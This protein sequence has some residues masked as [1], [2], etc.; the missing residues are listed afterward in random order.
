MIKRA[1]FGFTS[2]TSHSALFD[3]ENAELL[4]SVRFMY[5]FLH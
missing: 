4:G 1:H 5:S 3:T 2:D